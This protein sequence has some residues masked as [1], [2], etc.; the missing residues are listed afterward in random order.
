MDKGILSRQCR[1]CG[2]ESNTCSTPRGSLTWTPTAACRAVAGTQ[3]DLRE[4]EWRELALAAHWADL[5]DEQTIPVS[6]GPVLAGLERAVRLGGDGTPLVAEFA[7]AELAVLMGI[8]CV[9]A[10]H[11]VRDAL[12]L[13][14]RH[15]VLWAGARLTV[16]VGC[17]RRGGW[18]G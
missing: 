3:Q 17:G 18:R 14:H 9:A 5:H 16:G 4:A 15:P 8:G 11:L 1:R 12:D 6:V 13:R 7:C 10:E 2:L